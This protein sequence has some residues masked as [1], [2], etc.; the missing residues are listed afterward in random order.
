MPLFLST[1]FSFALFHIKNYR[2]IEIKARFVK[3]EA[4]TDS[5]YRLPQGY[6]LTYEAAMAKKQDSLLRAF[7]R[8]DSL[9][10]A[11][12]LQL[13]SVLTG[14]KRLPR[15]QQPGKPQKS[16]KPKAPKP[17]LRPSGAQAPKK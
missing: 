14:S 13:D 1:Q 10:R 2:S 8:T 9:L 12:G 7:K 5:V 16:S 15:P 4:P 17:A 6:V 3:P 11:N